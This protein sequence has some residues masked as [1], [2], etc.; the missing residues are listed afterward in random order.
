ASA[1]MTPAPAAEPF[2]SH[3]VHRRNQPLAHVVAPSDRA[4]RKPRA[5]VTLLGSA[6]APHGRPV[7]EMSARLALLQGGVAVNDKRVRVLGDRD[8]PGA[9][10]AP[11]TRM[12]ITYERAYGG[13]V[14]A[15]PI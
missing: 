9:A 2:R 14:P 10:P 13:T 5:E 8:A 11:F 15:N 3:D 7:A 1:P 4:P 6:C 12:P